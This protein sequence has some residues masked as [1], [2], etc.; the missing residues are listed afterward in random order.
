VCSL[1]GIGL[2]TS[3]QV[4][5][6]DRQDHTKFHDPSRDRTT[7]VVR[8]LGAPSH[9]A[10]ICGCC[11]A[12]M[13]K[14]SHGMRWATRTVDRIGSGPV[15]HC[16]VPRGTGRRTDPRVLATTL[17]DPQQIQSIKAT[18]YVVVCGSRY[19]RYCSYSLLAYSIRMLYCKLIR[20]RV[21]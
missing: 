11:T 2:W 8:P 10:A 18:I 14:L 3:S 16:T 5:T 19:L 7:S 15:R 13:V 12:Y 20:C 6:E 21:Q 1:A 17:S 4:N 9:K